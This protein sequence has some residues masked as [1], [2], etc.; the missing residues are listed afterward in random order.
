MIGSMGGGGAERQV[1]EILKRLNRETFEPY[2][3]L[4]IKQGEFLND[5]PGDVPIFAYWD[6]SPETWSGRFLRWMKITRILRYWHLARVLSRQRIDVVYD[7]TYLA[8]LDSS[9]GCCFR[10]TPRVSCCVAD[11]GP[12]LKIHSRFSFRLSRWLARR[13]YAAASVVITN[14]E[15]LRQRVVEFY[16]LEPGHVRVV[17]NLLPDQRA[18]TLPAGTTPSATHG[19]SVKAAA[20]LLRLNELL[21]RQDDRFLL[22]T[23]GRLHREKGQQVLLQA[24]DE[25]IHRRQRSVC[26]VIFG[27]G[28]AEAEL[29]DYIQQRRLESY[30]ILPGFVPE[31]RFYYHRANLFVLPSF[32]E[33]M[34]NALIEAVMSGVPAL[35]TTCPSGPKEI[36]DQGRC[37]GLVEPGDWMGLADAIAD[38]IDHPD[39]WKAKAQLARQRV[40]EMFDPT[41]GMH[42]LESLLQEV[43]H[44]DR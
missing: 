4:A 26:L 3:Y 25:L 37:G 13:A 19:R 9:G 41:I 6:G 14:S 2:L 10:P 28:K 30:V 23:A 21:S 24:I 22:V 11:P 36:L 5:V 35:A 15:G 27:Q 42:K 7:R 18:E 38:A 32:F 1:I 20:D 17:H 39:D 34:P 29:R 44:P 31:P 43:A 40:L 8:T 12:D 33:G 16:H